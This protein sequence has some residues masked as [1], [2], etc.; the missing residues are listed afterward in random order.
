MK[1]SRSLRADGGAVAAV[2]GVLFDCDGVL[3]DSREAGEEAWTTWAHHYGLDPVAVLAGL[4]G[5][6]S[7]ET[8]ARH[9][10]EELR[11]EGVALID[12]LELETA[13][14]TTAIPGAVA[15]LGSLDPASYAVVTSAPRDLCLARLAAAGF[16]PPE[17][18]VTSEDV[19]RGKPA[20]DCYLLGAERLGV[21]IRRCAVLE[22]SPNGIDAARA[23][24]AAMVI[25][26]GGEADGVDL[27]V[28]DLTALTVRRG[29][30]ATA[31]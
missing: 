29:R 15:L 22:D 19:E 20:P 3:V 26:V 7:V 21:P 8:V 25:G 24:G 17:T 5:R 13:D 31:S 18:L 30:L 2:D 1:P 11:A 28:P 16:A 9:L 10:P 14:R 27:G 12:G 4:H 23:A 6:R